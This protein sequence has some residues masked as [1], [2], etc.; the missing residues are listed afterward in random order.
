MIKSN[1]KELHKIATARQLCEKLDII[2]EQLLSLTNFVEVQEKKFNRKKRLFTGKNIL[3]AYII[4]MIACFLPL[5]VVSFIFPDLKLGI[6]VPIIGAVVT[7][8]SRS[9]YNKKKVP[10]Y[11][12]VY[13]QLTAPKIKEIEHLKEEFYFYIDDYEEAV[14]KIPEDLR[15]TIALDFMHEAI[16]QGYVADIGKAVEFYRER[17]AYIRAEQTDDSKKLCNDI[18]T[19]EK[20]MKQR[21]SVIKKFRQEP[22]D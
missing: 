14:E 16:R 21:I 17:L 1:P 6:F 8:I 2:A 10:V 12:N 3:L 7:I 5:S 18:K 15:Y 19:S 13:E 9:I 11:K 4:V 22:H 20:A